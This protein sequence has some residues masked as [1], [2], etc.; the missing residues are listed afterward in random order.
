MIKG[1]RTTMLNEI[2]DIVGWLQKKVKEAKAKGLLV[3]V[4]GGLDS[5]VVAYLIKRAFPNN[6]LGV[7][8][9]LKTNK[10]DLDDANA[11][12]KACNIN[13]VTVDL[14]ESHGILYRTI[15]D[16]LRKKNELNKSVDQLAD[17]NLRARLRMSTLYTLAANYNY[18]V[19]GTD[20]K[21]EWYTGYFTKYG[22]GGVDLQP[23]LNFTKTETVKLAKS[24][25]VPEQIITKKPSADLW[26]G[27]TDELEMG[28][29]YKQIDAFLEG[30]PVP[31]KDEAIIKSMHIRTEHKRHLPPQY[32][33]K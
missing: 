23:I 15:Q 21:S 5:A 22:D 4:S 32:K 2:N 6:S 13:A 27:Q 17:A 19:T 30:K 14:S 3:G 28:T 26:E 12:I 8:M 25:G 16:E 11:V 29:S 24:L 7:L 18:L 1:V 33:R 20:N 10:S 9:P 31:S